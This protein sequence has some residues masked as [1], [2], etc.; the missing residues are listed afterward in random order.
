MNF[1][2]AFRTARQT[3]LQNLDGCARKY[4]PAVST[5]VYCLYDGILRTFYEYPG[6]LSQLWRIT[7]EMLMSIG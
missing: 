5:V 1:L 6:S 7:F 4:L 2:G 3:I